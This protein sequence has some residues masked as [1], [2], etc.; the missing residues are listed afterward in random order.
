MYFIPSKEKNLASKC[1]YLIINY[2]LEYCDKST[3]SFNYGC[4]IISYPR[5]P[6]LCHL[7]HLLKFRLPHFDKVLQIELMGGQNLVMQASCCRDRLTDFSTF[8]VNLR[9]SFS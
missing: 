8:L 1:I 5:Y 6:Q 9:I 4:K 3:Q 2:S 7:C